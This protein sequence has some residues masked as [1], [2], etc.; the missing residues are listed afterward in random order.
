VPIKVL[1]VEDDAASLELVQEVLRSLGAEVYPLG[2]SLQAAALV[3]SQKFDGVFLDLLMPAL[4]G[5]ELA[6]RIRR[7]K[8][9][10]RTPIIVLSGSEDRQTMARAFEAGATFFLAKPLEK[11]KLVR[12]YNTALG[13]ML[14]ESRR[15]CA[16]TA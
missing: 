11:R 15:K 8:I 10:G 2:D 13:S 7:S 6:R 16:S 5:F 9:N 3:E 14:N 1:I 12:L 4:D